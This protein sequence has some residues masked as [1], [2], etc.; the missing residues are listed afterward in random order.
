MLAN[1]AQ[2]IL[3]R[4]DFE[5][6]GRPHP[7]DESPVGNFSC[8]VGG[9]RCDRSIE[10]KPSVQSA[11]LGYRGDGRRADEE[12]EVVR[13][14]FGFFSLHTRCSTERSNPLPDLYA[15]IIGFVPR[16]AGN[17]PGATSRAR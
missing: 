1:H 2:E 14:I 17:E 11:T 4:F 13:G 7:T 5:T 9:R 15:D 16:P 8:P 3:D 6:A 12:S 10:E